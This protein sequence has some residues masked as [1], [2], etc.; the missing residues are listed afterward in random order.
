M[1]SLSK[2]RLLVMS[3]DEQRTNRE[4]VMLYSNFIPLSNHPWTDNLPK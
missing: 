4:G 1:L 3:F 2:Y